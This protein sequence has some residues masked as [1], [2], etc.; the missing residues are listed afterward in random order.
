MKQYWPFS[1]LISFS[2][3]S[4]LQ[5]Y[6]L[7][8]TNFTVSHGSPIIL[9]MYGIS[10]PWGTKTITSHLSRFQ[11]LCVIFS[12]IIQSLDSK[13][14]IILTPT[15]VYGVHIKSLINR[16]IQN[17]NTKNTIKSNV[18]KEN[19]RSFSFDILRIYLVYL[20]FYIYL[21]WNFFIKTSNWRFF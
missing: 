15:T 13:V 10:F 18:S 20:K 12:T 21:E 11:N 8:S 2:G 5:I 7:L 16:I 6:V 14:G 1:A 4:S 17:T 3:V 19:F 9:F